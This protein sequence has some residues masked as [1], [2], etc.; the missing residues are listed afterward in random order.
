MGRAEHDQ[1]DGLTRRGAAVALKHTPSRLLVA[2]GRVVV[3]GQQG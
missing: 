3:V 2:E 1:V